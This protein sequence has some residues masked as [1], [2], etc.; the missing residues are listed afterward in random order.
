MNNNIHPAAL[1]AAYYD[2]LPLE[3]KAPLLDRCTQWPGELID[4]LARLRFRQLRPDTQ[5][6]LTTLILL[7]PMEAFPGVEPDP[8]VHPADPETA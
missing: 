8:F 2:A 6:K 1:V 7:G 4:D 5:Y 3:E